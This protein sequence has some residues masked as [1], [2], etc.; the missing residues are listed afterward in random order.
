[1]N[2]LPQAFVA[3]FIW[4]VLDVPIIPG[5]IILRLSGFIFYSFIVY[6]SVK[7]IPFGKWILS[8]LAFL[9]TSLFQATTLNADVYTNAVSFFFIAISLFILINKNVEIPNSKKYILFA[10]IIFLGFA[11]PGSILLL[12]LLIIFPYRKFSTSEKYLLI[13]TCVISIGINV[14]WFIIFASGSGFEGGGD[15]SLIDTINLVLHSP[16]DFFSTLFIGILNTLS[17]YYKAWLAAYGYWVGVVPKIIYWL[18]PILIFCAI[19]LDS[20]NI[21]IFNKTRIKMLIVFL[22]CYSGITAIHLLA[23]YAPGDYSILGR[24][25]RYFIP[26][27]PLFF[28][29]FVGLFNLQK[30]SN[31]FIKISAIILFSVITFIFSLGLITTYYSYCGYEKLTNQVCLLPKYKNLEIEFSPEVFLNDQNSISQ[32]FTVLCEN[33]EGF[34][35]FIQSLPLIKGNLKFSLLDGNKIEIGK[36]EFHTNSIQ[37]NGFLYVEIQN[38][39]K[40]NEIYTINLETKDLKEPASVGLGMRVDD[41]YEGKLQINNRSMEGDLIFHYICSAE[42]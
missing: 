21:K 5:I 33:V 18:F 13:L 29:S 14:G 20:A 39:L 12:V 40:L 17:P 7:T 3:G 11:K 30:I 19:I 26:F 15:R 37:E 8:I 32:T 38:R 41:V 31:K 22:F 34:D 27:T 36:K 24:Q 4:R 16:F 28:F 25:G 1:M 9:P 42:Q 23:S 35:V 6:F 10:T 2:F